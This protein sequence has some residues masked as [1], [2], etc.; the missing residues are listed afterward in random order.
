LQN[1]TSKKVFFI[2]PFGLVQKEGQGETHGNE[3]IL[4]LEVEE[5]IQIKKEALMALIPEKN[6]HT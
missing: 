2:T 1:E 5:E 3:A 4:A 6:I